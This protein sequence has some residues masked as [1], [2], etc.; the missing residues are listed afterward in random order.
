MDIA[1]GAM[2]TLLPKLG[3]LVVGEYNLQKGVKGEI[4]E[5]EKELTSMTAALCR[6]SAVP[7]DQL[8]AQVKIWASD[9]RELSYDIEDAVNTFML[10]GIGHEPTMAFSLKGFID[11]TINLFKK[12]VTNHQIHNVIKDIMHQVKMV[13]ERRKR[14]KVDEISNRPVI[15]PRLEG[16]YRRTAE[17]VGID[18]PKNELA[19]QLLEQE[20][21][22]SN[23]ISIVRFGGLGETTLANSLLQDLKA[24]FDCHFFVSYPLVLI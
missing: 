4:K 7:P 1:T 17:L 23:I 13:N 22:Q 16:M 15:D 20:G 11:R 9:V 2:N 24:Q 5:L 3:E 6:V 10:Q 21:L 19:K 8:D 18:G 14:Y 12:A